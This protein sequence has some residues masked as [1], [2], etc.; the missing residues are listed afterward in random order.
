MS[1]LLFHRSNPV[2]LALSAHAHLRCVWRLLC[3]LAAALAAFACA[4]QE[5]SIAVSR[6]SLSL[7]F[8]VAESQ[9]FFADEGVA[10]KTLECIGGQ[11]CIKL[12][13]EGEVP[14]ATASEMPVMFN[15]F[16]RADYAIV[17]TFV[18]SVRDVKLVARK[19]AGIATAADLD[20]KRI[21]TVKGTSAHY[22]LDSYLLFNGIDP[23]KLNLVSLAPEQIAPALKEGKIDAAA[24]WE[25]FAQKAVRGLA[26]DGVVL[27]S[28]RIYTESFNLVASRK[29]M[30]DRE[31]DLIKVLRALERAQRFIREQPAQAQAILKDKLQ[32]DQ[33]FID[34]TWGD[35]DYRLS[36]DQ[37]LV[38]TLEGQARWAVREG[39]VPPGSRTPNYLQFVDREALRKAAP[40]AVTLVK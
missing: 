8:Y 31:A 23:K 7:P 15:S 33:A 21:G 29:F 36:L 11:R 32:E 20:G 38:S 27:P 37:S 22:F 2:A 18:T 4:A 5:L 30:A 13:F 34:A 19:S 17:A 28:A 1:T 26:G 24:I 6:T 25:P 39:H 10:V 35:F 40:G 9:R 12:M 14:L 3:T 16:S